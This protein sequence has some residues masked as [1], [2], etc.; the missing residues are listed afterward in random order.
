MKNK[1]AITTFLMFLLASCQQAIIPAISTPTSSPSPT[2]AITP[3]QQT[4][5][6]TSEMPSATPAPQYN[7]PNFAHIV[8]L[9]FE[10]KEYGY[11]IDNPSMPFYN[12]L[13]LA[14]TTLTQYYAPTHPSL[15]NYLAL[16]GGDTFGIVDDCDFT[17]CHAGQVSL[18]DLIEASGRTW[19]TYQEGMK[20]PCLIKDVGGYVRKHNP[21]IFFDPIRLNAERCNQSVVPLEYL[22][23]DIASGNLPNYIF[24]TPDLCNSS[25]DCEQRVADDWLKNIYNKIQPALEADSQ[26]YLIVLTWDEGQG[27]HSC[28]GIPE[29]AGGRVATVLISPQV[30]EGFKDDTPYTHYSLVK[31]IAAAWG[32]DFLNHA[33]D[34]TTAIILAPWK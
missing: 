19:K 22:D 12:R 9:I 14:Y 5:P 10:N 7:I 34:E 28:C 1:T 13:S 20:Q 6:P 16:V 17:D 27:T 29:P 4:L 15:P 24:I 26:P 30:K 25:H 33:A 32:L 18:P 8:I 21:F 23:D 11:V 3:T 31:T 2:T